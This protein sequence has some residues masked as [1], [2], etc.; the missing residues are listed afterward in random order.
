MEKKILIPFAVLF[1][2]TLVTSCSSTPLSTSNPSDLTHQPRPAAKTN[3]GK[4]QATNVQSTWD[5]LQ[6]VSTAKLAEMQTKTQD[7]QQIAW[8]Q[9]A[10]ITKQKNS[11]TGELAENLMTWRE[12]YPA[13]AGNQLFPDNKTLNQLELSTP[14]TQIAVLLPQ[15]GPYG[16][17][18]QSVR[19]GF[20]NAY[21]AN[22]PHPGQ[23]TVKFYD[24]AQTK[25]IAALYQ[26]AIENGADF[27]IGPLVKENVQ[28]L[29]GLPSLQTPTLALNYTNQ[30]ARPANLYEFGLLPE[31]EVGQ[32]AD[33]ANVAG[34]SKAIVIA[35]QNAWGQRLI[36]SFST[37]WLTAGGHIQAVWYYSDKMKF[38]QEIARLLKVTAG[39]NKTREKQRRQDFDVIFLFSQPREARLI[40]PFLRYYYAGDIPVYATAST[41]SG[42]TNPEKDADLKGVIVCDI[43]WNMRNAQESYTRATSSDRLYAMGQDAYMLSQSWQRLQNLPHFPIYGR[44]GALRLSSER[45]IHRRLPCTAI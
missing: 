30:S 12:R 13:H 39:N 22:L 45:Q 1:F 23:Q 44:T 29:S 38:D 9:L 40:V 32:L 10:M 27:I 20:L 26:Q 33:R 4:P 19:E 41:Y 11:S 21:Y 35:P 36:S 7:A 37:R 34:L 31:D 6:L 17:S 28:Q 14:P 25:N 43:P 16:A 42:K 3:P 5:K 24:T 8:I 15:S 18:G 2:A